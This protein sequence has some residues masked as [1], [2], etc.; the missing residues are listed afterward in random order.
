[1]IILPTEIAFHSD[2]Q[3]EKKHCET[4]LLL[5]ATQSKQHGLSLGIINPS[6]CLKQRLVSPPTFNRIIIV[7]KAYG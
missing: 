2:I 4:K 1:M 3:E 5:V 6:V 7:C